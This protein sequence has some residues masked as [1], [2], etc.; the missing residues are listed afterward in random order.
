MVRVAAVQDALE[1]GRRPSTPD[2]LPREEVLDRIAERVRELTA[3]QSRI[4]HEEIVPALAENGIEM[5]SFS[6]LDPAERRDVDVQFDREVYPVLTPLAVGPGPAVPL[7]LRP[8]AQPGAARARSGEG[9]DPLRAHQGA[10]AAAALPAGRRPPPGPAGGR[11]PL[12]RGAALPRD[13]GA[14]HLALPGH[15]RR[16]LLDLGRVGRPPRR[17]R[18][19]AA[20]PPLRARRAPGGGGG[21]A[22]GARGGPDRGPRGRR[23]RHL[24]HPAAARL[25]LAL[26]AGHHGPP[27]PARRR[28]GSRAPGR[29]CAPR[30]AR[31]STSSPRS[32]RATSSCTTPTT[33]STPASSASSSRRSR[34]PT[35]SPSSRPCTAPAA[36]R[37]SSRR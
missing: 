32:A 29:A 14:R 11:H 25:H 3:E 8:L 4:W 10:A 36:T 27:G 9:R 34:T 22:R 30:R 17:G 12:P 18:G 15:A 26:G 21:R 37:R 19:P 24:P 31:S 6:D 33:T 5:V 13:G 23:P 28:R 2:Q 7:H 16:G 1:A 35:S 20:P